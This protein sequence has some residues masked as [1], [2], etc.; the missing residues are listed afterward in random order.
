MEIADSIY[1]SYIFTNE[2]TEMKG[3]YQFKGSIKRSVKKSV[4]KKSLIFE[5]GSNESE[6]SRFENLVIPIGLVLNSYTT[7]PKENTNIKEYI[8]EHID[9]D[10]YDKLIG[11]TTYVKPSS[12]KTKK[13]KNKALSHTS[14]LTLIN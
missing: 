8:S 11:A 6:Y 2:N 7:L 12:S 5:G 10:L 14:K 3:G 13:N 1:K 9:N 4:N